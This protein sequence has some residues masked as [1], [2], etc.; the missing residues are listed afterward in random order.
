MEKARLVFVLMMV[1]ILNIIAMALIMFSDAYINQKILIDFV[2]A[3]STATLLF[4][5]LLTA[6]QKNQ[7]S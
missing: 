7:Q 3:L 2:L 6:S 5:A 1:I 4:L